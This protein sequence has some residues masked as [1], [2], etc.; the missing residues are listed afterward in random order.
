[1]GKVFLLLFFQKKKPL[2]SYVWSRDSDLRRSRLRSSRSGT[3]NLDFAALHNYLIQ[4][5]REAVLSAA[6][7]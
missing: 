7:L 5:R 3:K 4:A 6:S 1:M 2:P